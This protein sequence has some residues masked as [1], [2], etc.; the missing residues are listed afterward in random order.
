MPLE[1][2]GKA[3]FTESALFVKRPFPHTLL[4]QQN[5]NLFVI[6]NHRL[7]DISLYGEHCYILLSL[8]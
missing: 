4:F 3:A 5:I 2:Y 6:S 1:E 8:D 7:L